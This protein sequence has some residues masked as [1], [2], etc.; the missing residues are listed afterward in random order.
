MRERSRNWCEIVRQRNSR[1]MFQLLLNFSLV[2]R[3][4][5][6]FMGDTV[7]RTFSSATTVDI[8]LSI[9]LTRRFILIST[10]EDLSTTPP[11]SDHVCLAR[12][13]PREPRSTSCS[14]KLRA[15]PTN[16]QCPPPPWRG[17]AIGSWTHRSNVSG[18]KETSGRS[19][20]ACRSASAE[21]SDAGL[22]N[23]DLRP[24][25]HVRP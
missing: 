2:A 13:W 18:S 17:N 1:S 9:F 5:D 4:A 7:R 20:A 3:I 15:P 10:R 25:R 19:G 14:K 22:K 8:N 24:A 21:I 16:R 12:T 23:P 11:E 6:S